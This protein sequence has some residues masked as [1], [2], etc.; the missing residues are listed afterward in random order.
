M[1]VDAMGSCIA[2]SSVVM[3]LIIMHGTLSAI[4]KEFNYLYHGI[5]GK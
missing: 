4:N 1:A 2:T 5:V 3:L